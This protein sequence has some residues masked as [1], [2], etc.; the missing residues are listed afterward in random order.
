MGVL[1]NFVN[2]LHRQTKRN[3]LERMINEKVN[4]SKIAKKYGMEY[5][6]GDRKFGYGGYKYIPGRWKP[7]AEELIK[8]YQLG[9]QSKVLDVGCGKGFLIHEMKLLEPKLD[10]RGLDI[11]TYAISKAPEEIKSKIFEH[12]IRNKFPFK[13]KEFNLVISLGTIHNLPIIDVKNVLEEIERIGK[14]SYI[15]VEGYRNLQELFN[16]QCWALTC[17]SFFSSEDWKWIFK[18]YG[19]HG[20]YEFIFFD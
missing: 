18:N 3:Y 10:V 14:S 8:T 6:D 7:V 2:P 4:C 9:P 12:D 5:W 11:S 16:L 15:M 19:Y 20:D 17:E 13:N 1:R